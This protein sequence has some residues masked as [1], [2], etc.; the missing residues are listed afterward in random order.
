LDVGGAR[1]N[2]TDDLFNAI[3]A[4]SQLSYGPVLQMCR[5]SIGAKRTLLSE[6]GGITAN[7]RRPQGPQAKKAAV[8]RRRAQNPQRRSGFLVGGD[9]AIDEVGD[10][11]VVLLFFFKEGIIRGVLLGL[12]LDINVVD[13]RLGG[14]LLLARLDLVERHDFHAGGRRNL[15][16]LFFFGFGGWPRPRRGRDLEHGPAFRADDGIFVEIKEFGAAVLA[17][18]FGSEF[19]L[20]QGDLFPVVED[21]IS[22]EVRLV[23]ASRPVNA[24]YGS[25]VDSFQR[26]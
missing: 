9:I 7:L 8:R 20:G 17:L 3:E 25:L 23:A 16:V 6:G 10:V 5:A 19:G 26:R 24:P 4:L 13:R 22:A 1:R 14:G 18:M 21:G 2:R 15:G 12:L 11:V